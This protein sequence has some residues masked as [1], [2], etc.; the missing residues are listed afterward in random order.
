MAK[1]KNNKKKF[2]SISVG[3][4]LFFA[5]LFGFILWYKTKSFEFLTLTILQWGFAL[6]AFSFIVLLTVAIVKWILNKLR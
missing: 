2:L 4:T 6:S 5:L 3:V 1:K